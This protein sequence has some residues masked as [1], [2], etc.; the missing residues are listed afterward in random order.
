MTKNTKKKKCL[1]ETAQYEISD[2][3]RIVRLSESEEKR[4][5]LDM[6]K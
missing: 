3:N 2:E 6:E 4:S 1:H 5:F